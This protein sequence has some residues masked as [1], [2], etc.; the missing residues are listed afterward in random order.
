MASFSDVASAWKSTRMTR[1]T[2]RTASISSR[3]TLNGLSSGFMKTRPMTLITATGSPRFVRVMY[4]PRP[5]TP[6]GKFA[7]RIS[8]GSTRM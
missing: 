6:A 7:G 2:L 3:T 4:R 1:A 5:G 8:R